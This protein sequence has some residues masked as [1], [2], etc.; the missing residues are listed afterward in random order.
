MRNTYVVV[1]NIVDS[2]VQ[3][4]LPDSD[5][6]MFPFLASLLEYTDTSPIRATR[7]Y[8]TREVIQLGGI[9]NSLEALFSL[10]ATPMCKV[11]EVVYITEDGSPEI[12]TINHY[13]EEKEV[14]NWKLCIGQLSRDYV[15][16][17]ICS[18][19]DTE[20]QTLK[21]RG[22]FK[23]RKSDYVKGKLKHPEVLQDHYESE[24]ELLG[25]VD[26]P[27]AKLDLPTINLQKSCQIV[28]VAGCKCKERTVFAFL[29]AQYCAFKGKT[30]IVESDFQF[31]LLSDMV[32]RA[33]KVKLLYI[34]IEDVYE[35]YIRVFEKIRTCAENL[36]V[37]TGSKRA[38]MDYQ[39]IFQILQANLQDSLEYMIK[40]TDIEQMQ[41]E[42]SYNIVFPNNVVDVIKTVDKIPISYNRANKYIGIDICSIKELA[43]TDKEGLEVLL[44][45]LLGCKNKLDV[46]LVS[47]TSLVL[48]SE[49][50]DL[51]M[52]IES[53]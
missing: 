13:L 18:S 6:I 26:E 23:V 32:A 21:R 9:R 31:L 40:E 28:N 35:D 19:D 36:I 51:R 15:T 10:L 46:S 4:L 52:Y 7:M 3:E 12:K 43:I 29:L 25:E 41:S 8:I 38:I 53:D 22:V 34:D 16:E 24:E 33:E 27:V 20:Q 39:F 1:S 30:I 42:C 17:I 2:L 37:I 5:V 14:T 48:G 50:H 47:I 49:C 44:R 45:E 11:D